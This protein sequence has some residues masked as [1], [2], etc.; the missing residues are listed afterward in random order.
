[1]DCAS[2]FYVNFFLQMM[3]LHDVRS[4]K[5]KLG[6]EPKYCDGYCNQPPLELRMQPL[7][8]V[9]SRPVPWHSFQAPPFMAWFRVSIRMNPTWPCKMSKT[10]LRTT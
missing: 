8:E 7:W 2:C 10:S 6:I 1:M 9:G 5:G 3:N 4:R